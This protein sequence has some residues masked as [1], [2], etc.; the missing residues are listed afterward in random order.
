M[1]TVSGKVAVMVTLAVASWSPTKGRS[2]G[3][4]W[5]WERCPVMVGLLASGAYN[6]DS[7]SAMVFETPGIW[8]RD[9][10]PHT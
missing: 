8:V 2:Y 10:N 4:P 6:L 1:E 7:G 9:S 3:G 5:F